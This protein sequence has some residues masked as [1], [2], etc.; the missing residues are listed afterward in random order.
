M[1]H[2]LAEKLSKLDSE[3]R[4]VERLADGSDTIPL[5]RVR[6]SRG[7]QEIAKVAWDAPR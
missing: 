5:L 3:A 7:E 2:E 1:P 6:G 4:V